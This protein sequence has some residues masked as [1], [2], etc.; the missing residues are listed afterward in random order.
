MREVPVL[1]KPLHWFATKSVDW[2]LYDRIS[3]MKELKLSI[4][5]LSFKSL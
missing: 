5:I 2:C 3:D 4:Q 1:Y